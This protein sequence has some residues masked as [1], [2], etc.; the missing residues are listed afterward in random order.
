MI[1]L[2]ARVPIA[3]VTNN[4][5]T[6]QQEKLATFGFAPYVSALITSEAVGVGKPDARMF[7]AALAACKC[8]AADAVMVGDSWRHDVEG[9]TAAGLHAVWLNRNAIAHPDPAR[10]AAIATLRPTAVVAAAVLAAG[11]SPAIAPAPGV[12][13]A[14]IPSAQIGSL[15]RTALANV[16]REYPAKLDH[17][18]GDADDVAGPRALHPAFYGAFDWH[19]CVHMHWL[20]ARVG[21]LWPDLP[22]RAA[23]ADVFDRHLAPDTIAAECAYAARPEA[24]A[25]ERTYGWAWLLELAHELERDPAARR[26]ADALAPL[27]RLFA[28][29]YVDYLPRQR[30]PIRSGL[31][32]SSAFGLAFALDYARATEEPALAAVCVD[33]AQRWFGG[34]RDAPAAWEPSGT[35]F[36]SPALMEADLM[37]RVLP[38]PAFAQWLDGFLPGIARGVP[39]AL[40]AP[41]PV[42]DRSDG[43]LVHLDGLNLS[44]AWNMRGIAAAL[45]GGDPRI[46][47]LRAAAIAHI[48]AGLTGLD[49]GD[50]MGEHWLATFALLAVTA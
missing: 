47:V 21:R 5:T 30:Y 38:A 35:D 2:R 19:S 41:V 14:G 6:E 13:G 20:L 23:I 33:A 46:G 25:F 34:D 8:K 27:A 40:F 15:A 48:E 10:A 17:V 49:S 50:Y 22:E 1:A 32:A 45:P 26:W 24:R 37:R 9:A 44:R 4:T 36:L 43:Y 18:L 3:V 12:T 42:T 16:T 11:Q 39:D 31:H 7:A 28:H 29:R